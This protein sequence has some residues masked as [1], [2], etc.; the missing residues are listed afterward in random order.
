MTAQRL[1]LVT[2]VLL[3]TLFGSHSYAVPSTGSPTD[4]I[5]TRVIGTNGQFIR[6]GMDN[7]ISPAALVFIDPSC[8][9]TKDYLKDINR[10]HQSAHKQKIALYGVISST[11]HTAKAAQAYVRKH[12][13]TAP[14]IY[15]GTGELTARLQPQISTESFMVNLSDQLIY[16]GNID[17]LS[18]AIDATGTDTA[19]KESNTATAGCPLPKAQSLPKQVTYNQHIRPLINANCLT[20]HQDGG[21]APFS[22][23]SYTQSKPW[24]GM[25]AHV[26]Q[27]R[28]MPPWK[29][30]SAPG[31]RFRNER[32]LTDREIALFSQWSKQGAKEGSIENLMPSPA[33]DNSGWRLG[34]PDVLLTMDEAFEVPANG[35]DVYRYFVKKDA[36]P[37][38][39]VIVAVDFKPGDPAV[40]HHCNFFL[41]YDQRARKID[42]K[43]PKPGFQVFG[44]G[45]MDYFG[46][47]SGQFPLGAWAPGGEPVKL[48]EGMGIPIPAGGDFVIEIHYHLNGKKTKDQSTVALYLAKKPIQKTVT[49]LFVGTQDVKIPAGEKNYWRHFYM[50]VSNDLDLIDIAA[51]MHYIGK[52]VKIVAT[53]PDGA[54]KPLLMIKDWDIRWQNVYVYREPIFIPKGSRIDAWFSFDNSAD[55]PANPF[56]K[57]VE[58]KWGWASDEEMAEIYLTV[59]PHSGF[60]GEEWAAGVLLEDMM[61]PWQRGASANLSDIPSDSLFTL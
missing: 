17:K 54:K 3:C 34:K 27:S 32:R 37:K 13:I 15:D 57:P 39:M 33:S 44:N 59:Y 23:K 20:C 2:T 11:T 47:S 18:M 55:N 19:I 42:A 16:H 12:N 40:V 41:D 46:G 53:L 61:K 60:W 51:H 6:I 24:A 1:A 49:G 9:K 25:M 22:L 28:F 45:F 26:T 58:M 30:I 29:G 43:D 14:V 36:I 48:P 38:D 4:I 8:A 50:D 52:D 35:K 31:H 7:G 21:V 5:G 10:L 56:K